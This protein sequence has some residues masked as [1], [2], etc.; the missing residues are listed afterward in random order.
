MSIFKETFREFVYEQLKLREAIMKQGNDGESRFG[1]P[2][3]KLKGKDD[4]EI[5][6]SLPA[7]SFYT[8]T[9][10]KQCTIRM[11]SGVDLKEDNT[12]FTEDSKFER[13]K[14]LV[15]EGL[16]IRYILEGGVPAKSL[17][18]VAKGEETRNLN[19]GT[20]VKVKQRG[21]DHRGFGKNYGSSYGD[22][23]IR[24]DAKGGYGI[25]P[26]PG[27][28]D[29]EIRTK[30]AYGSLREAK[31]N[32]VCHNKRQLEVLELLYMRPG[33]PVL[34]E[35]GWSPYITLEKDKD[36][37]YTSKRD[38]YFPYIWDWFKQGQDI[39]LINTIIVDRKKKSGGN[40]DGFVGFC[41]NFEF[42]A[43]EDG[44]YDCTTEL[45][46]M[47][48]VLEGLKGRRTGKTLT[49]PNSTEDDSKK[50]KPVD[51]LEFYLTAATEYCTM[52]TIK[53]N[54]LV[55]KE[56]L[57]I[58]SNYS[59]FVFDMFQMFNVH[60]NV[61]KKQLEN[62]QSIGQANEAKKKSTQKANNSFQGVD[63]SRSNGLGLTTKQLVTLDKIDDILD[64][65]IIRKG[66]ELG[67]AGKS[68]SIGETKSNRNYIRW[69]LLVNIFNTFIIDRYQDSE[70]DP[71]TISELTVLRDPLSKED[72]TSQEYLEY[73]T[74]SFND[75]IAQANKLQAIPSEKKDGP[76]VQIIDVEEL[77]DG[78]LNPN[79]CLL[80]H[81]INLQQKLPNSSSKGIGLIFLDI[82]HLLKIYK[83]MRYNG[84]GGLNE[85]FNI[86]DYI[87]K[88]WEDVNTACAGTHEFILQT[89]Q[90]R[91]NVGR[92]IDV[93]I[94]SPRLDPKKLFEFKIQSNESIVRDFNYNT[95]IPSSLSA[96]IAIAAQAPDSIN[97]LDSV[98]FS[99]FNKNIKYRFNISNEKTEKNLKKEAN[100]KLTQLNKDLKKLR[101]T[102]SKLYLYKLD[103]MSGVYGDEEGASGIGTTTAINYAK[104]IEKQLIS[105]NSRYPLG[106]DKVGYRRKDLYSPK[107]S[108]IP[109]KFNAKMDGIGGIVIGNVFK[110]D[111]TRLPSGYQEDN[112]A[113]VVMAENQ[114]ITAGQDWTTDISGQLILLDLTTDADI[115]A[116]TLSEEEI[117]MVG[118]QLD[119]MIA[120]SILNTEVLEI[121]K[122]V[123]I[124]NFLDVAD[125]TPKN[126]GYYWVRTYPTL[127]DLPFD[128]RGINIPD[129]DRYYRPG[130][131]EAL[132][133]GFLE[134]NQMPASGTVTHDFK[135][136]KLK[137]IIDE[138]YNTTPVETN[139]GVIF[140]L[141][142]VDVIKK[143]STIE[144][145][146]GT[147]QPASYF[148]ELKINNS[149]VNKLPD[150]L[151]KEEYK[152]EIIGFINMQ[153]INGKGSQLNRTF[154]TYESQIYEQ[155]NSEYEYY[156]EDQ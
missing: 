47:G 79:I 145:D 42:K 4:K 76:V 110:V 28:T 15:N 68:T 52:V 8:N 70:E 112:I 121:Y 64:P 11:C 120:D 156:I 101:K 65:F 30:T 83:E 118:E 128:R 60:Q 153:N 55:L 9:V 107:S 12:I 62:E 31:V 102:I 114:K 72:T 69:D 113:F 32:F 90:E 127:D 38:S 130:F 98:T 41:K 85:D 57:D 40:Y 24:S 129:F 7:G 86:F 91:S 10:H 88:I 74:F 26:M 141:K 77:V 82:Q 63:N 67:I 149:E 66:E 19:S 99:A 148:Y 133:V 1:S 20:N 115:E 25:V 117:K 97:D 34:L 92:I 100:Q 48:E 5:T 16:A 73:S 146:Q 61:T 140:T 104:N 124:S 35:W 116:S 126:D 37:K 136:A 93:N 139:E 21:K 94:Q 3:L 17:D 123:D 109:L 151:D 131:E 33:Y 22:P 108:I 105:I 80:P 45:I 103:I 14:D 78:S 138:A 75:K 106:H 150:I 81:Q 39:N 6:V 125:N 54:K 154:E 144:I 143:Q 36:N 122:G 50:E 96:T 59:E 147:F 95:T 132:N 44:G 71:K 58:Y 53:D 84:E 119:E 13:S 152:E 142:G 27:I 56:H 89:E 2:R 46:A 155:I 134:V 135:M 43:R 111:K 137:S 23:Y 87:R 49:D 29:A 18:R 51:D